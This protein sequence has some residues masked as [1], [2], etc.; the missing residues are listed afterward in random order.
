MPLNRQAENFWRRNKRA[1]DTDATVQP[2]TSK[3][4]GGTRVSTVD[5]RI[6]STVGGNVQW[7]PESVAKALCQNTEGRTYPEE[8]EITHRKTSR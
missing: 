5:D 2:P 6:E 4:G 3:V 1:N 7:D 8:E